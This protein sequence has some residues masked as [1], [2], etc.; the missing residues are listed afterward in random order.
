[1]FKCYAFKLRTHLSL[2]LQGDPADSW[3]VHLL[4]AKV[5][6]EAP[7]FERWQQHGNH[8]L[9]FQ[10]INSLCN[11]YWSKCLT[12]L[13]EPALVGK[14]ASDGLQ[15]TSDVLGIF[16]PS[17]CAAFFW[18]ERHRS[19]EWRRPPA[20][21]HTSDMKGATTGSIK[22]FESRCPVL[23]ELTNKFC[24][25]GYRCEVSS[26]NYS[27]IPLGINPIEWGRSSSKMT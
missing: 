24:R 25:H 26:Y 6:G 18:M 16:F 12:P 17:C 1:M 20:H 8:G 3:S 4:D 9:T 5:S 22:R 15:P 10:V 23:F 19:R 13:D 11:G 14:Y 27:I 21:W 2:R 7:R